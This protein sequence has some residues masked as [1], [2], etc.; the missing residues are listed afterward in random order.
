M[1]ILIE[2]VGTLKCRPQ[3]RVSVYQCGGS[4]IVQFQG[5]YLTNLSSGRDGS[6]NA[7]QFVRRLQQERVRIIRVGGDA[8]KY[9]EGFFFKQDGS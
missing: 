3:E 1:L 8:R 7:N 9:C 4:H 6:D 5:D 2:Y